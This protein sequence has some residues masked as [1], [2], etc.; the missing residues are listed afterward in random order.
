MKYF[1]FGER[2]IIFYLENKNGSNLKVGWL[3]QLCISIQSEFQNI[4]CEA[5]FS[6]HEITVF[7]REKPTCSVVTILL[8]NVGDTYK[9]KTAKYLSHA[10][11]RTR[12]HGVKS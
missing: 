7:F 9:S 2:T 12:E 8:L 3:S 6:L 5:V 11:I 4:I 1:K 10:D